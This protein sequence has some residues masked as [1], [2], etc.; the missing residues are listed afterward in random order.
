MVVQLSNVNIVE[1]LGTQV[2]HMCHAAQRASPTVR[3]LPSNRAQTR[4]LKAVISQVDARRAAVHA[5]RSWREGPRMNWRTAGSRHALAAISEP[6]FGVLPSRAA[7]RQS[8]SRA[9]SCGVRAATA[10]RIPRRY[11]SG[12]TLRPARGEVSP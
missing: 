8:S 10:P 2:I 11:G 12:A 3:V 6:T 5:M 1:K 9:A 7:G 4:G